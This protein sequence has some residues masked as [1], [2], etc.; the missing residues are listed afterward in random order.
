MGPFAVFDKVTGVADTMDTD[1]CLNGNQPKR[2]VEPVAK[3]IGKSFDEVR[4]MQA[5][6]LYGLDADIVEMVA[7]LDGGQEALDSIRKHTE[8]V[9][10]GNLG[11]AAPSDYAYESEYGVDAFVYSQIAGLD[12]GEELLGRMAERKDAAREADTDKVHGGRIPMIGYVGDGAVN[13]ALM[14]SAGGTS[15]AIGDALDAAQAGVSDMFNAVSDFASE[16]TAMAKD[17]LAGVKDVVVETGDKA[18]DAGVEL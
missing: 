3:T 2:A 18:V 13:P 14:T 4:D 16:R 10:K 9:R 1:V 12:G 7:N 8:A 17:A 11:T 15:A 6:M 5:H